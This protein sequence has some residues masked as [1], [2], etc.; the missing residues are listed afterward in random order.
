MKMQREQNWEQ[1]WPTIVYI[2]ISVNFPGANQ[3]QDMNSLK[4][5][6]VII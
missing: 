6:V 3:V 5:K 1:I 2:V 4:A